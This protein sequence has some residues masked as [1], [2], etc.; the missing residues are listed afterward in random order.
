[1]QIISKT[2][3]RI[4]ARTTASYN[5]INAVRRSVEEVNTL[6][7][8]DVEIT[9]NDSAL[10]DEIVAHRLGLVPLKTESKATLKTTAELTLKKSGPGFVY[11]G[12]LR[13]DVAVV[14][15]GIPL[16]FLEVGQEIEIVATANMGNGVQ[17]AKY[18]P[19]LLYYRHL[20]QVD[21]GNAKIDG[22]VQTI[23]GVVK[24]EKK[25]GTWICDLTD[26]Q[27]DEVR[28][29]NKDAVHDA[30]ELLVFVESFGHLDAEKIFLKAIESLRENIEQFGEQFA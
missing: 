2:P 9:K 4:V 21:A 14:Y 10:Y 20:L 3:E 18:T 7:I 12:D 8:D 24:P 11:S 17:H 27:A 22:I 13:G 1:M 26:A 25:G 15:P 28:A 16:T 6:A 29:I 19:G 30:D 23:K 5:L